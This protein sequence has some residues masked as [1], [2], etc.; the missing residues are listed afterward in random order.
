MVKKA[1]RSL[2]IIHIN[3]IE[4]IDKLEGVLWIKQ[5]L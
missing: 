3:S 2:N 5:Y 1:D 4:S